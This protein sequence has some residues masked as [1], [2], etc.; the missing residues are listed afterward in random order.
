MDGTCLRSC[1][2]PEDV[3]KMIYCFELPVIW[4]SSSLKP[5]GAASGFSFFIIS[6]IIKIDYGQI[7]PLKMETKKE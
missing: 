1:K 7:D 5:E 6:E 3:L 4:G 2:Q